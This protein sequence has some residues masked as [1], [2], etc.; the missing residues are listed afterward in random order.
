MSDRQHHHRHLRSVEVITVTETTET[1]AE[2]PQ[3]EAGRSTADIAALFDVAG[4]EEEAIR[5]LDGC[6]ARLHEVQHAKA[7]LKTLSAPELR[8][9]LEFRRAALGGEPA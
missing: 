4:R 7:A 2:E 9:A 8:A 1:P 3:H 5:Q 6:M